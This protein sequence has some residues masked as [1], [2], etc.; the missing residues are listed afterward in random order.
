VRQLFGEL[1]DS[2]EADNWS[3][4]AKTEL[5]EWLQARRLAVPAYR[6]LATEGLLASRAGSGVFVSAG[7]L[8]GAVIEAGR[9][10]GAPR[11]SGGSVD[12]AANAPPR[13]L[14]PLDDVKRFLV[15]AVDIDGGGAFDYQDSAGYLPLREALAERLGRDRQR[16]A[17]PADVHIVSGAQQ[18]L[19][20]VARI[21]LRRG[22]VAAVESPG[23]RGA[24]DSFL[25]AGARIEAIP[26]GNQG[27]DV[28]ALERIAAARPLRL[29]YLNPGYQNPTGSVYP[30]EM[31]ER[32]ARMAA[33]HGFYIIEDDQSS[34]LAF[35]GV[36]QPS[37]RSFDRDDRVLYVKSF[38]K[39]LMP[40]LRI[41]CLEAPA[42]F[43]ERL[44]TA[45]RSID[46][47]SNGLMQRVLER[48]LTSGSYEAHLPVVR[49]RYHEA[50]VALTTALEPYRNAGLS[51]IQPGGGINL[52]LTLPAG[53]CGV[54]VAAACTERGY[55]VAP[56]AGFRHEAGQV[57]DEHIRVSFGSVA[58]EALGPA[59][60][61]IGDA[62]MECARHATDPQFPGRSS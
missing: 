26:V 53:A 50:A 38:S 55:T 59:A 11:G 24:R 47:S 37:V 31:R 40:G 8:T 22:D 19:D 21:L 9:H 17:D 51:W 29:V 54:A 56:E 5:Q 44:E 23:Y 1:I 14:Y 52:W 62:V 6:I 13:C 30:R 35:D 58:L 46:L 15:E 7:V 10:V 60:Q 32:L 3:K 57:V 12:L 45:K 36:G 42:A 41:A 2:T 34:E 25:A 61:A 33:R 49:A 28:E 4:D 27:I 39:V 20:L 48:F 16:Y 43:R 18:G